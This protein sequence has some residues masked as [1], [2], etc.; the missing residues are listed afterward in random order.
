[1]ITNQSIVGLCVLAIIKKRETKDKETKGGEQKCV[2]S[3][4]LISNIKPPTYVIYEQ[5]H[6]HTHT[7]THEHFL[8]ASHSLSVKT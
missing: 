3:V 8:Y 4:H 1:M 2:L 7:H 6:T 5:T